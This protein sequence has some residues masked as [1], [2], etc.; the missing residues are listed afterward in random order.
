MESC[1]KL[2]REF[3]INCISTVPGMGLDQPAYQWRGQGQQD[4]SG[5]KLGILK[6]R[7]LAANTHDFLESSIESFL[8]TGRATV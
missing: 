3:A 5:R 8:Q 7:H 2:R 1:V 6:S 4:G